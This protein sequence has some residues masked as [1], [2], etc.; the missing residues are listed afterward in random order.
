[1]N[2]VQKDF[3]LD[4]V[5]NDFLTSRDT[6][7][8]KCDIYEKENKYYIEMDT[9]GFSK[10]NLNIEC[11]NGYLTVKVSKNEETS[12]EGKNYIR[13]EKTT[14]EYQ[15]SFYVGDVDCDNIKASFKNGLLTL[16]I[17]KE[18]KLDTKKTIEIE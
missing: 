1:M 10:E 15:R 9:P 17:P 7:R 4:D 14:N 8:F 18:E 2:L 5:F 12:D 16:E 13:R 3:F 6:S 11:D